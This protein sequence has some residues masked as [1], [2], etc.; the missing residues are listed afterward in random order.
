MQYNY[1]MEELHSN[2][3]EFIRILRE[4]SENFTD[5]RTGKN[6][7]YEISDAVMSAF[8]IFFMQ[9]PSF[10]YGQQKLQK[11]RRK[12]N[13]Q[14][15]FRTINIPGDTQ[16]RKILDGINPKETFPFFGDVISYLEKKKYLD[17]FRGYN[18][19]LLIAVDGT[20]YHSSDTICCKKCSRRTHKNGKTTYLHSVIAPAIVRPGMKKNQVLVIE[21]EFIEPQDG[22]DKQ[23]CEQTAFRRWLDSYGSKYAA[24]KATILGDDLFC[25]EPI[26]K[27]LLEHKLDFIL[28]CKESSHKN[29]FK[30]EITFL[31]ENDKI[32][33]IQVRN[34]TGKKGEI[35]IYRWANA[36]PIRS[37][38]KESPEPLSVNWCEL[39]IIDENSFDEKFYNSYVTNFSINAENVADI[40]RDGRSRW[41]VE[42]G[43]YNIL[44]NHGYHGE[45]NFGH[46][47]N[48]LSSFL[49][50]LNLIAF[51]IHTVSDLTDHAYQETRSSC[52]NYYDFFMHVQLLSNMFPVNSWSNLFSLIIMGEKEGL[53]LSISY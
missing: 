29:L 12:N 50:T 21:P 48:H 39:T 46:G 9:S 37:V 4:Q 13:L 47:Q 53:P 40:I 35:S 49:F 23:D 27:L 26:C 2:L 3:D 18:D 34:W 41:S 5:C 11:F 7:Q 45:H 31:A 19:N 10:L 1:S 24:K 33:E 36:L 28:T 20:S 38:S 42:N 52:I 17:L 8:S 16:I 22:N 43:S 15:L 44:K 32:D 25:N 14:S 51:L 6:T 30:E